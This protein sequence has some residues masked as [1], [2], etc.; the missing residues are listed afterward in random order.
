MEVLVHRSV[1]NFR[2]YPPYN[3]YSE[4]IFQTYLFPLSDFLP[5]VLVSP[6]PS[7]RSHLSPFLFL[8]SPLASFSHCFISIE[9]LSFPSLA[10]NKRFRRLISPH[11]RPTACDGKGKLSSSSFFLSSSSTPSSS[12]SE[13]I[14]TLKNS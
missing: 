2:F 9:L 1:T 8:I 12:I 3:Y 7:S 4:L 10:D 6:L 11:L 13:A 14:K 5:H